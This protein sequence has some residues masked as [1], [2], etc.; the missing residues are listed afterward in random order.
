M[1]SQTPQRF[2]SVELACARPQPPMPPPQPPGSPGVQRVDAR[3]VPAPSAPEDASRDLTGSSLTVGEIRGERVDVTVN[4]YHGSVTNLVRK[5]VV[6]QVAWSRVDSRP[7]PAPER[8]A[9]SDLR[10][11]DGEGL[12]FLVVVLA[13]FTAFVFVLVLAYRTFVAPA[14]STVIVPTAEGP[15]ERPMPRTFLEYM[16]SQ[17]P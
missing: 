6:Q 14:P 17:G 7:E 15:A 11:S 3:A 16:E 9:G 12:R 2:P 5:D 10:A 13:V 1:S 8:R 4:H